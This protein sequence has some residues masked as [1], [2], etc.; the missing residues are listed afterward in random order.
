MKK[1]LVAALLA[2]CIMISP[3]EIYGVVLHKIREIETITKGATL[4]SDQILTEA[5][6]QDVFVIKINLDDHNIEIKPIGPKALG[7]KETLM[8]MVEGSGALAAINAD[9]FSMNS[10]VP[11]FGPMIEAGEVV[12][13]YNNNQVAVGPT[14]DGGPMGTLIIDESGNILMNYFSVLLEIYGNGSNIGEA[15]SYNKISTYVTKPIILD[16]KY[17]KTTQGVVNHYKGVSTIVVENGKVSYQSARGE[18]VNIPENGYVMLM[19]ESHASRYYQALPVGAEVEIKASVTLNNQ[20]IAD[21]KDVQM[22]IGGGGI[23]MQNGQAYTGPANI[24]SKGTRNPRSVVATTSNPNELLLIALDGRGQSIGATHNELI[25]LLQS[26]GVK[27]ALYLDGGGS[28]TLIAREEAENK[29]TVQNKPSDGTQRKIMNG[30]GIFTTSERGS[31]HKL[32]IESAQARTFI[33]EP[34]KLTVKAVDEN[35]N[36][37]PINMADVTFDIAGVE[38]R[39]EGDLFYPQTEGSAAIIARI[40][41]VQ[42]ATEIFVSSAP[43]GLVI[44]PGL[45]TMNPG[46]T[47]TIQVYGVDAGG[48]KLPITPSK[49][50]WEN[51]NGIATGLGN[52][53]TAGMTGTTTLNVKY[54]QE[55]IPARV[56]A[57]VGDSTLRVESFETTVPAWGGD[58]S[59][60]KGMVQPAT[61]VKFEGERSIKMT[62]TFEQ[63]NQKQVAYTILNQPIMLP[64]D[65]N[66]F[67]I[68]VNGRKQGDTLKI[69]VVDAN[70]KKHYLKLAETINFEG[71]KHLSVPLTADI[72]MPA[73]VTKIYAYAQTV[74]E[75]RTTALYFDHASITRGDR[76]REG[77]TV[78]ND[79]VLDPMY[80]S[81]LD[82]PIGEEYVIN[83]VGPTK[84]KSLLLGEESIKGMSQKILKDAS[85]VILASTQNAPLSLGDKAHTYQNNYQA[86]THKNT[87]MIFVGTD[88]G[89]IRST[90]GWQWQRMKQTLEVTQADHIMLVM[91][92]NPLTQFNDAREGRALHDYLIAYKE[93]T[94]KNIFV[95]TPGGMEP[96]VR[97]ESGI[98]Y[99]RTPGIMGPTDDVEK[100]SFVKFKING[101][102]IYYTFE[103]M[104]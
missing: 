2:A 39:M 71:W 72:A 34:V 12:Q 102:A 98:R 8:Q 47:K 3:F 41:D 26:Y 103:K 96:E 36:P 87:E 63:S 23:L 91:S 88:K 18:A 14:M 28:T 90:N 78:K 51:G 20:L 77:I 81:Q 73:K 7:Q 29:V 27:D 46:E 16:R 80:K 82:S 37:V 55:G 94:G 59:T 100:G 69:E 9:F 65:A 57:V 79:Y 45:V 61:E 99:I 53:M 19:D 89:G 44:E 38:G 93:E 70:G 35:N 43:R 48:Y 86:I 5:G 33:E 54:G 67:N 95:I 101:D 56:S 21:I 17:M 1:K 60:V 24:V 32:Y 15:N 83:V 50:V 97:L 76:N 13:A 25:T 31:I 10:N 42:V 52:K 66:S 68:W 6:W 104:M 22:G 75:K 11:S 84:N 4:I 30:I 58:T 62:Y 92:L 74:P 40:G 49:L 64:N 85:Q